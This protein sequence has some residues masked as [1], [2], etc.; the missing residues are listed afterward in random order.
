MNLEVV[1]LIEGMDF[2]DIKLQLGL[3]CAPVITGLKASS[4]FTLPSEKVLELDRL[5]EASCLSRSLLYEGRGRAVFLIYEEEVLQTYLKTKRVASFFADL[6][7]QNT[8]LSCILPEFSMRYETFMEKRGDFPH[9]LGFLLHY[10]FEDVIGFILNQ[11]RNFLLSGYWKVYD[12][13]EEKKR[14]FLAFERAQEEIVCLLKE[15]KELHEII[16][17]YKALR[18]INVQVA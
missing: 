15:E 1:N 6:G 2:K 16:A 8:E 14:L 10:P 9:E 5:L 18:K 11:G 7:Y 13:E 12:R 3:Q 17:F 4:L